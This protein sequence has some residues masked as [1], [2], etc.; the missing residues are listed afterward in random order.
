MCHVNEIFFISFPRSVFGSLAIKRFLG[1]AGA[2]AIL[3]NR[4]FFVLGPLINYYSRVRNDKTIKQKN[5]KR[6]AIVVYLRFI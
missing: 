4:F 5:P 6:D 1:G 3:H 2:S